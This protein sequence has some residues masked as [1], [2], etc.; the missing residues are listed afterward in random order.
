MEFIVQ[1]LLP[2][3][4]SGRRLTIVGSNVPIFSFQGSFDSMCALHAA[5]MA[6]AM[7]GCVT[8]PLRA[9]SRRSSREAE[10]VRKVA[11]FWHTGISLDELQ[12]LIRELNWGLRPAIFEGAHAHV[13]RFSEREV[14]HGRPVI[15]TWRE[16]HRATLHAVLAVGIEG[17]QTG[18]TFEG[19]TLLLIDSAETEPI[20]AVHNARLTWTTGRNGKA[21]YA[22][23]VTAFERR[24]VVLAGA[25]SIRSGKPP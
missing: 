11:P 15:V 17:R 14:L 21:E 19:H 4:R 10:Y 23:Y 12:T 5:A 1:K 6:L 13:L 8:N 24:K 22:Q 3:L 20:L 16:L 7:H 2:K 9:L 18:R 25:M